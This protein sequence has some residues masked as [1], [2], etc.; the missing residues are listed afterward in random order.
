MFGR[1]LFFGLALVVVVVPACKLETPA[2]FAVET[3]SDLAVETPADLAVETPTD[4]PATSV[5]IEQL[6]VIDS[7]AVG[8]RPIPPNFDLDLAD[9]EWIDRMNTGNGEWAARILRDLFVAVNFEADPNY[10][11][12]EEPVRHAGCVYGDYYSARKNRFRSIN[13]RYL[14][15][16]YSA[17]LDDKVRTLCDQKFDRMRQ[18]LAA[19]FGLSEPAALLDDYITYCRHKS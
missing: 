3:P 18:S 7:N 11:P 14:A 2:D 1:L 17:Y 9:I 12:D 13:G 19:Q 16:Y 6:V 15:R 5:K 10:P 4:G 8:P